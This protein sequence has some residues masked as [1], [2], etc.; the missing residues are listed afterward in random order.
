MENL[1]KNN[2][3]EIS[4][5]KYLNI[6]KNEKRLI[7]FLAIIASL[8]GAGYSLIKRPIWQGNFEIVVKDKN[9]SRTSNGN[10]SSSLNPLVGIKIAGEKQT[11]LEILK[12]PYILKEVYESA[13]INDPKLNLNF[14]KWVNEKLNIKY[15]MGTDILVV[16]YKHYD[17]DHI[18]FTLRNIKNRFQDY[19]VSIIQREI[20]ESVKFLNNKKEILEKKYE[21]S[22][23]EFNKFSIENGLGNVDG[24]IKLTKINDNNNVDGFIKLTKIND[25]NNI[26]N[27]KFLSPNRNSVNFSNSNAAG[28]R[29]ALQFETLER[30]EARYEN[31]SS[32]LKP[33]SQTIIDLKKDID[34]LKKALERPNQIL[35]KYKNLESTANRNQ[36]LLYDVINN[37]ELSKLEQIKKLIPWEIISPPTI[38]ELR[39]APKRKQ[40]VLSSLL[41]SFLLSCIIALIKS[42][43]KGIIFEKEDFER[44][45]NLKF[46]DSLDSKNL[47]LN[48]LILRKYLNDLNVKENI[49]ILNLIDD[50]IDNKKYKYFKDDIKAEFVSLN[51]LEE[52]E[53]FQRIVL[54]VNLGKFKLENLYIIK[55]YLNIYKDKIKALFFVKHN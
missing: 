8:L 36:A 33:N 19:S 7:I 54:I 17:K 28:Q 53:N 21:K 38:D 35:I 34:H 44:Y 26:E 2:N 45:L 47:N 41:G 5:G 55:R 39:I 42:K 52:L 24:F 12:S 29:Y 4:F 22:L 20:S 23:A 14:D 43:K 3:D 6:I 11:K 13:K 51:K 25:N 46:D 16:K 10:L 32:K 9:F 31:L 15:K 50:D 1:N 48:T 18:L 37:L 40:I 30:Y 49:A 27:N